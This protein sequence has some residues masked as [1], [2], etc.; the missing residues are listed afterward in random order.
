MSSVA[1]ALLQDRSTAYAERDLHI[2]AA[3]LMAQEIEKLRD[4]LQRIKVVAESYEHHNS[5][6]VVRLAQR[7]EA[8]ARVA[9]EEQP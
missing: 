2:R 7:V 3:E 9:L 8:M 5:A 4:A 1:E 6:P